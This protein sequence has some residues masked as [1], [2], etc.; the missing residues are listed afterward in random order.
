M[1]KQMI[2]VGHVHLSRVKKEGNWAKVFFEVAVFKLFKMCWYCI[3]R[4]GSKLKWAL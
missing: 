2:E 4:F 3:P 1:K